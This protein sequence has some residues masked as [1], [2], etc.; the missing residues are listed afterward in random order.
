MQLQSLANLPRRTRPCH[1]VATPARVQARGGMRM[2]N[3]GRVMMK[4]LLSSLLIAISAALIGCG[5][6]SGGGSGGSGAAGGEEFEPAVPPDDVCALLTVADVQTIL[7]AAATSAA[8]PTPDMPDVWAR[9][10]KWDAG[11]VESVELVVYGATSKDGTFALTVLAGGPGNGTKT[12]V[13]GLGD[14][15]T[16]WEDAGINTRG[17]VALQGNYAV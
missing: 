3:T 10:C 5:D 11:S 9:I 7:P 13:G 14:K 15:A 17:V 12:A 16:Y 6:D 8:E 2:W 4:S 1:A